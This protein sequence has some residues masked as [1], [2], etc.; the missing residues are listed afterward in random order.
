[1]VS[2]ALEVLRPARPRRSA[3]D[4]PPNISRSPATRSSASSSGWPADPLQVALRVEA[5]RS[6]PRGSAEERLPVAAVA[7]VVADELGLFALSSTTR[8]RPPWILERLRR[9]GLR[10]LVV[11]LAV[12]DRR[13]AR[14]A[15]SAGRS[16]RR[17][18]PSRRSCRPACSRGRSQVCQFDRPSRRTPAGSPRRRAEPAS[19]SRV[20]GQEPDAG[21]R[22]FSLTC[23]LWMISPVRKT[24]GPGSAC[25]PGRR[26]RPRGRRRSR[27]RTRGAR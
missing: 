9:G 17:S 8:Y 21:A 7:D 13:E 3:R 18:A 5:G 15:R 4:R 11:D 16:S 12:D 26:S 6:A 14:P 10:L 24:R 27:S 22:S 23:G 2:N 25:A 20:V 1:M 19:T